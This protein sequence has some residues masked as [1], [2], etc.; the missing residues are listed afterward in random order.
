MFFLLQIM[1][2]FGPLSSGSVQACKNKV[3]IVILLFTGNSKEEK[4]K[5]CH[6]LNKVHLCGKYLLLK[7]TI[8]MQGKKF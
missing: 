5:D 8:T 6:V 1:F 3:H 4:E 7:Y 2:P